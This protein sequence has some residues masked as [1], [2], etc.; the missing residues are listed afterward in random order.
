M[1]KKN[2]KT[3]SI[4]RT[5]LLFSL[6]IFSLNLKAQCPNELPGQL[7]VLPPTFN[8]IIIDLSSIEEGWA[9][10]EFDQVEFNWTDAGGNPITGSQLIIEYNAFGDSDG[11]VVDTQVVRAEVV[12]LEDPNVIIAQ[13]SI[14]FT[15]YPNVIVENTVSFPDV[16]ETEITTD[17]GSNLI[18]EY[19]IDDGATYSLIPP[20]PPSFGE[21]PFEMSYRI[22][23][24]SFPNPNTVMSGVLTM[25]CESSECPLDLLIYSFG[26]TVKVGEFTAELSKLE[27]NL[28]GE[29]ADQVQFNW[30]YE[31]G[32]PITG[33]E[34]YFEYSG[35]ECAIDTQFVVGE[36]VCIEDTSVIILRDSMHFAIYPDVLTEANI[37]LPDLCETEITM[38]C[39]DLVVI[40]YSVDGGSTYS[41]TPPLP[42]EA[43]DSSFEMDYRIFLDVILDLLLFPDFIDLVIPLAEGTT[44]ISCEPAMGIEEVGDKNEVN[45]F[46]NPASTEVGFQFSRIDKPSELVL[47]NAVGKAVKTLS[48]PEGVE[49]MRVNLNDLPSGIYIW[50]LGQESGKLIVE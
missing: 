50:Q 19:S 40:R 3:K 23:W 17:C 48:I 6:T 11:C 43:N 46:P 29:E 9:S 41:M 4:I 26:T 14:V 32:S 5:L 8:N 21:P 7:V 12:C 36:A 15:V 16:C 18:I 24:E 20:E 34:V 49:Q 37:V 2:T 45:V 10:T 22:Y 27:F 13:D 31:D 44:T 35:I 28:L 33:S 30:T 25:A 47:Y 1:T 39:G 42:P 38:P